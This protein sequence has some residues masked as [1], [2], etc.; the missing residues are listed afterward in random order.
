MCLDFKKVYQQSFTGQGMGP[1]FGKLLFLG[2]EDEQPIIPM[3]RKRTITTFSINFL[4]KI[5]ILILPGKDNT[6]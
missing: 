3:E 2:L 5:S 6:N 4:F 1:L